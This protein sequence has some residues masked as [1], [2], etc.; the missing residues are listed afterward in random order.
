MNRWRKALIAASV[1]MAASAAFVA[2]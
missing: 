1:G 2:T